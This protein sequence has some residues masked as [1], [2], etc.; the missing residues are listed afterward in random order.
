[1]SIVSSHKP[2]RNSLSPDGTMRDDVGATVNAARGRRDTHAASTLRLFLSD[3]YFITQ[4]IHYMLLMRH[5]NVKFLHQT[6]KF[7]IVLQSIWDTSKRWVGLGMCRLISKTI[8][9][10]SCKLLLFDMELINLLGFGSEGKLL[11]VLVLLG[12]PRRSCLFLWSPESASPVA[13]R[14][15]PAPRRT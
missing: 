1:M 9:S 14:D 13:A 4:L 3:H 11:V 8:S 5:Y 12:F 2:L 10:S 6:P 15:S 7:P